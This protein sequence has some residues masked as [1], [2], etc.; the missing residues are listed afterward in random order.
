[1]TTDK[2]TRPPLLSSSH[3]THHL[4]KYPKTFIVSRNATDDAIKK[5]YR[6]L[7]QVAHPDKHSS[8]LLREAAS[9]TFGKINEA[10]EILSDVNRRKIYDVYGMAGLNAGLEVGRK[11]KSL[12]EI[13]EEFQRA[14]AKEAREVMEQRLNFRGAYGFSFSAAHLFDKHIAH[15]RAVIARRRGQL[16]SGPWLDLNGLDFN[17]V[18]D[19][20]TWKEDTT[21]YVGAQGQMSRGAGAGGLV[22]GLRKT[23][24]EHTSWEAA[25]VTGSSQSAASLHVQ[26]VLSEHA[27]GHLAYS[28]SGA[29]GGLGLEVGCTRALYDQHTKGHLTWN[30]GPVGGLTTGTALVL[31]QIQA[32]CLPTQD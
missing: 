28:F 15:R 17:S 7:A 19:V 20:P 23:A 32:H 10:Y 29:Q 24:S 22:L 16:A 2:R 14:K 27:V 13:T 9:G 26:R 4:P 25:I 18:F 12:A 21:A 30:V 11:H 5:A 31:S 3:P 8:S 1:M 6:A